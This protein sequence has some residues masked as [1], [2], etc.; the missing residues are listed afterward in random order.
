MHTCITKSDYTHN[1][2]LRVSVNYMVI[3]RDVKHK[4]Y[5]H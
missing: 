2:L 3:I 1:R 5:I 4:G